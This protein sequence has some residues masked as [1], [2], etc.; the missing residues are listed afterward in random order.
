MTKPSSASELCVQAWRQRDQILYPALFGT[1]RQELRPLPAEMFTTVFKQPDYEANWTRG[2]VYEFGPT[3]QRAA[4]LYVTTGLSNAWNATEKA[5]VTTPSGL[6]CEFVLQ[7]PLRASWTVHRLHYLMAY[8]LLV[9]HGRYPD[10]EVLK[11]FDQIPLGT[12]I[13]TD[14]S[15]LTWLM[16]APPVGFPRLHHLVTGGFEFY[17]VVGITGREAEA[18]RTHGGL[19]L[20]EGLMVEGAYPVTA[21]DRKS[22][23]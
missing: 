5:D 8:H 22:V 6:G 21:P 4:W 19:L 20:L 7:T 2:G 14:P 15:E 18:G 13:G 23:V 3:E 11:D 12:A 9:C 1:P 17:Q 10:R 16:L